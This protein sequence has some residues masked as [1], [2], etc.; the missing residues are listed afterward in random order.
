MD[1]K[2][3]RAFVLGFDT[4]KASGIEQ[5]ATLIEKEIK[6]ITNPQL[7]NKGY[8]DG[9]KTALSIVRGEIK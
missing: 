1:E 2:N 5:V 4:G 9:L 6:K 7:L 3:A 8:V